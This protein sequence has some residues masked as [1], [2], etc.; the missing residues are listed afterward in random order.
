MDPI[1]PD[2]NH[3]AQHP[4]PTGLRFCARLIR[5]LINQTALESSLGALKNDLK[6]WVRGCHCSKQTLTLAIS[7]P[8]RKSR[9]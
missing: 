9:F 2:S 1:L 8:L 4:L 3:G 5:K 7:E 6:D